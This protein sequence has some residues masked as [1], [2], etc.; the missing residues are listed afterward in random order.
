MMTGIATLTL[1]PAVVDARGLERYIRKKELDPLETY[2][3]PILAALEQ[4]KDSV[5]LASTAEGVEVSRKLL[6]EGAFTGLRDNVR[7]VALYAERSGREGAGELVGGFFAALQ[8]YDSLLFRCARESRAPSE[9][10]LRDSSTAAIEAL[11]AVLGTLPDDVRERSES[12]FEKVKERAGEGRSGGGSG[13][14]VAD[15]K[16]EAIL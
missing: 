15:P 10:E 2:V 3:P 9:D 6:R 11:K 5:E 4:L 14:N 1:R 8:D 7:A 13:E 12:I 16:L